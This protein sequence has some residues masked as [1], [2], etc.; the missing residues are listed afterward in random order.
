MSNEEKVYIACITP[1]SRMQIQEATNL[2]TEAI[3]R[4]ITKLFYQKKIQ[5]TLSGWRSRNIKGED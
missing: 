1:S 3:D 4:A 2:T 5:Y